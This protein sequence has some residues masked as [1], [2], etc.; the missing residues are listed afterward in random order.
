MSVA[1]A[2]RVPVARSWGR[3]VERALPLLRRHGATIA[4]VLAASAIAQAAVFIQTPR[5]LFGGDSP[6]Y[7]WAGQH[8]ASSLQFFDATRTPGYPSFLAIIFQLA[9][10]VGYDK[11]KAIPIGQTCLTLAASVEL[12]ILTY[13][14]TKLRWVSGLVAAIIS[15]NLYI[16]AW[17][18]VVRV[19]AITYF[20]TLTLFLFIEW[21]LRTESR[22]ALGWL[23]AALFAAIMVRPNYLFF[24]V[25]IFAL[26]VLRQLR[27]GTLRATW[28]RTA[29]A[30]GVTY[31][32]VLGYM[33]G[34]AVTNAYFGLTDITSMN[35]F[36]KVLEYRM[37]DETDNP[38]YRDLRTT[39]DS[40]AAARGSGGLD[41][42]AF[43]PDSPEEH[44]VKTYSWVILGNYSQDI[45][46][47][48]IVEYV[49]KS[50]P[51]V[52][53]VLLAPTDDLKYYAPYTTKPRWI[54][55]LLRLSS[56]EEYALN[57]LPLLLL[58]AA[59]GAF[60]N[61]EHEGTYMLF[62]MLVL[63]A[64]NIVLMAFGSY[65]EYFRL[66]L[67]MDFAVIVAAL[68]IG[69]DLAARA[70]HRKLGLIRL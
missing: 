29:V 45:I 28:K 36:G 4:L 59:V 10:L 11:L 64:S 5:V 57:Y 18:R 20:S 69:I 48:H 16:I 66:R 8:I 27:R 42:Y 47:H 15:C 40:Y 51:D 41:P 55:A 65:G 3:F 22:L 31:A 62:I 35:Q 52:K 2:L 61:P 68:I 30:L 37:F 53:A 33:V 12:Y 24:P 17:E 14:L 25:I 58:I 63:A 56:L 54:S 1:T 7:I 39:V 23:V 9:G 44:A 32:L 60:W 50:I 19:E 67:P 38:K 26:L 49:T 34:N 21:Y 6:P 13:R 43:V 70:A 46:E